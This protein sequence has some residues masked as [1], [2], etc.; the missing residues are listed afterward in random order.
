VRFIS[1]HKSRFGVEPA[2]RVLTEHGCKIAPSTYYD[3][4]RRVLSAAAMRDEQ[5]KAG[6]RRVHAG[7]ATPTIKVL[8]RPFESAT[9]HAYLHEFCCEFQ[10]V[11][12]LRPE[13]GQSVM[14][15][16]R[17]AENGSRIVNPGWEAASGPAASAWQASSIVAAPTTT[18]TYGDQLE[19]LAPM[20]TPRC[21]LSSLI[22][23]A[24]NP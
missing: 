17:L 7:N 13:N 19:K 15:S 12:Q 1:E 22:T 18:R 24:T 8:R 23:A 9:D 10:V 14:L 21:E 3:A 11:R 20:P 4:A 2:Y 6:I 5:L 16:S